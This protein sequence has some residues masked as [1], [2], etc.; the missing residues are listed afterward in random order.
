MV[1]KELLIFNLCEEN[2][3]RGPIGGGGVVRSRGI[4]FSVHVTGS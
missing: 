3:P 2:E 4:H 1:L